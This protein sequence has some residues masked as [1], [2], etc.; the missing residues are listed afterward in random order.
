MKSGC[1]ADGVKSGCSFN[2][3]IGHLLFNPRGFRP[4]QLAEEHGLALERQAE[5]HHR[6]EA[7]QNHS[8]GLRARTLSNSQ[9][10]TQAT[11]VSVA[12]AAV[13][14]A[15]ARVAEAHVGAAADA[16]ITLGGAPV[17]CVPLMRPRRLQV[18][19]QRLDSEREVICAAF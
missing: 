7:E 2:C 10:K 3:L 13:V 19:S 12:A 8:E 9:E 18:R 11:L 4:W 6:S 15:G 16:T 5:E 14:L 17:M 1:S